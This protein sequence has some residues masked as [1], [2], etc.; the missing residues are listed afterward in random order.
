[1]QLQTVV[2]CPSLL[3]ESPIS[4]PS[5]RYR[6]KFLVSFGV[7]GGLSS[8]LFIFVVPQIFL[9]GSVLAVVGVTCL[10]SSFVI[11]NSFLP[12]LV[13]NHPQVQ[14]GVPGRMGDASTAA[15]PAFNG[16]ATSDIDEGLD[17]TAKLTGNEADSAALKLSTKISSKG[18]GIG[19]IA[20]VFVQVL[21]IMLLFGMS[22]LSVSSTLPLRL[23]LLMVGCW[24]LAFTI[25][26]SI[27]LRDRPG[28]LL[29]TI[30]NGSLWRHCVAYIAF[31]WASVWKTIKVAVRL[32][33]MVI[34][35]IAW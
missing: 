14:G 27:W 12:L 35:L 8:A 3:T 6:K 23:V 29:K 7:T 25:P 17:P 9:V 31:S 30:S 2:S 20:A 15:H 24:W 11:L 16:R 34:F 10:G 1:M 26:A 21:S 32:R 18:V 4:P 5:G 13:A 33:Q 22:K 28:P 19:Y